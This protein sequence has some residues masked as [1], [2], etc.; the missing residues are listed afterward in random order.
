MP[1]SQITY[2]EA[3]CL[4]SDDSRYSLAMAAYQYRNANLSVR[5]G[6]NVASTLF[7]YQNSSCKPMVAVSRYTR[8]QHGERL[9]LLGA[10]RDAIAQQ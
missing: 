7:V 9:S 10:V 3:A 5:I 1:Q 8:Q 2:T 4:P 6:Q